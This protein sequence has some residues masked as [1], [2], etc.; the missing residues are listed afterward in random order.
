MTKQKQPIW[1]KK[2]IFPEREY[3]PVRII[4]MNNDAKKIETN[5]EYDERFDIWRINVRSKK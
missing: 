2:L 1:K 3:Q 4:V 5:I